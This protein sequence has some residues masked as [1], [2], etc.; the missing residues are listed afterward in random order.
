MYLYQTHFGSLYLYIGVISSLFMVG[1]TAGAV[2]IR[3]LLLNE[4]KIQPQVLLFAAIFVHTLIL[5]AIAFWPDGQWTHLNFTLAF[6][7]CGLCAGC[8]FPLAAGQLADSAFET[9]QVGSKLETADHLGAAVGGMLTALALV[10]VLGTRVTLFVFIM[11]ILANTP[12]A[13]LRIY[14]P[15]KLYSSTAAAFSLRRLGYV[16]FGVGI[17]VILCSNLLAHAGMELRPSLP[18]HAAQALAG[19]LQLEQASAVVGDSA[20]KINYFN[21]YESVEAAPD[22]TA[23]EKDTER[24]SSPLAAQKLTGYIISSQDMAP[25]VRGFG[26]RMNLAVYMDTAGK[27]I[28]FHIIRSNETPAYLKLLSQWRGSLNGR[29][30]F[31]PEPFAGIHA[32]TG[33]T[34]SSKAILSALQKSGHEF[35]AQVLGRPLETSVEAKAYRAD[36]L[37]DTQGI[38]LIGAF[39]LTLIAIY[40]GSF[41]L[42]LA[43]LAFNLVAGGII[44]NAQ[45]SSEQIATVLSLHTPAVGLAGAFLLV[46]GVPVLVMVF[47]NIYCGYIC[48][49]GAA[50]E[51]LGHVVP[52]RFKQLISAEKMRKA[53]FIKYVILFVL[54]IVFF[55]SRNRTTLATDPLI[56]VFN[57]RFSISGFQLAIVN[58]KTTLLLITAVA[59]I[60]SVFYT[61]FWCRYLCPVGAFLSL[62]NSVVILKHYLPAK[63][64]GRCEF[65]LTPEDQMDCLYCD[66]CR[67]E[68]KAAPKEGYLP[69]PHYVPAKLLG[70]YFVVGVLIIAALVS[71]VSVNRFLQVIPAAFDQTAVSASG[72]QPR[73]VDLQSIRTMIQQKRL[74]DREAEFYKKIE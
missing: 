60:G 52:D 39:V 22:D 41:R 25:E 70:R 63:K 43:V 69:P 24:P 50:Q 55:L 53:R 26:G 47:G 37:P 45:Y 20:R 57:L 2:L 62:F 42:R 74:S 44:L 1:L 58:W 36:Y 28:N 33:A 68:A 48:P 31:Q 29:Q 3:R 5:A 54:V 61:R 16:L 18:Q 34:V 65:G 72:G 27:L 59:L 40:R 11:L 9:G 56:E 64:F 46:M 7:L 49:F 4:R 6:V 23:K 14:R 13:A 71:T 67:Y 35:A 51:L 66:R 10:P 32:V 17:A 38:Y 19:Q 73:D 8:Y 21:V 15:E 30:L 12:P